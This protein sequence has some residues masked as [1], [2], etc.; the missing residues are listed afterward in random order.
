[1]QELADLYSFI[2][3]HSSS[4][5]LSI[6]ATLRMPEVWR[7]NGTGLAFHVYEG[8]TYQVRPN[9]LALPQLAVTDLARFAI[10]FG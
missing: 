8:E 6:S 1:L 9:S 4:I 10:Q 7:L 2:A 3:N 5:R